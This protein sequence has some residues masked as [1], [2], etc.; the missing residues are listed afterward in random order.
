MTSSK[1]KSVGRE[2][3]SVLPEARGIH[4]QGHKGIGL[5]CRARSG[6][7]IV[8]RMRKFIQLA[9]EKNNYRNKNNKIK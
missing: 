1:G 9:V 5:F 6:G 3:T 7:Y 2:N 4:Y 8:V